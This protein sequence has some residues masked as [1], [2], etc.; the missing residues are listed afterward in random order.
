MAKTKLPANELIAEDYRKHHV[1]LLRFTASERKEVLAELK[2]MQRAALAKLTES[3]IT[4]FRRTKIEALL[5][6]IN[7]IIEDTYNAL[8]SRD[9]TELAE[10][11]EAFARKTVGP[12]LPEAVGKYNAL[13]KR[14]IQNIC[15]NALIEGAPSA[16]WWKRQSEQFKQFFSDTVRQGMMEGQGISEIAQKIARDNRAQQRAE[17][18]VRSSVMEVANKTREE[19]FRANADVVKGFQHVSTF[20]SRTTVICAARDGLTWDLDGNPIGHDKVFRRPPLHFGCLTG[21]SLVSP[22]GGV[23][24]CSKRWI[25][26]ELVFIKTSS[27]NEL[28]CTPNHPIL[29]PH[30]WV[31]AGELDK[32]GSVISYFGG[33]GE[34]FCGGNVKYVPSVLE[35]T[36]SSFLGS[37]SVCPVP[38]PVSP[39]DFHGDG[40]A[41]EIAIIGAYGILRDEINVSF[42]EISHEKSFKGGLLPGLVKET[43]YSHLAMLHSWA[44]CAF[45]SLICFFSKSLSLL[46]RA[47]VHSC[48][49][50]F[51]S[52]PNMDSVL[53]KDSDN[54]AGGASELFGDACGSDSFCVKGNDL[55]GGDVVSFQG[56]SHEN[57]ILCED[58]FNSIPGNAKPFGNLGHSDIPLCIGSND[59]G[60]VYLHPIADG[61]FPSL[62]QNVVN[63]SGA[64][65]VFLGDFSGGYSVPVHVDNVVSFE[66][67]KFSGHVYNLQ[68]ES[69][70]YIANGII[71][72]NCRS[73]LI[74]WLYSWKELGLP[75]DEIPESTRASMDGQVP[76]KM[77]MDDWLKTKDDSFG[78]ELLGKTRYHLWKDGKITLSQLTDQ[79]GRELT[80]EELREKYGVNVDPAKTFIAKIPSAQE[81]AW[82][83]EVFQ[84]APEEVRRAIGSLPVQPKYIETKGG[85]SAALD[86]SNMMITTGGDREHYRHALYHE[87]GHVVDSQYRVSGVSSPARASEAFLSCDSSTSLFRAI[88]K[89]R[90]L[91]ASS[92]GIGLLK[93]EARVL[94]HSGV[95][96]GSFSND[97]LCSLMEGKVSE[98]W[99]HS[100]DYYKKTG[101]A[102]TEI[103]AS[104]F[105]LKAIRADKAY[106]SIKSLL[107]STV[108]VFEEFL[109]GFLK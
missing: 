24:S 29:T 33:E 20:D 63:T 55:F 32:V 95:V 47:S 8:A 94:W 109:K 31:P 92:D 73:T 93:E 26:G 17:L 99:G 4:E 49:L 70:A 64:P 10:I 58:S 84:D 9:M 41:S 97:I 98:I 34:G 59:L 68:T 80:V 62:S 71:T 38:V 45:D 75:F 16:E 48:P 103:F 60:F 66:R 78:E 91:Y 14:Q 96:T 69:S 53:R 11:E 37:S 7:P 88:E 52:V 106:S 65:P 43:A 90:A 61:M 23:S 81:R 44:S 102:N 56:M 21:N 105:A 30:G 100:A 36:V 76:A 40:G 13:T 5:R 28:S 50:L 39:E 25:E 51:G 46:K 85:S 67:R 74:P 2:K 82:A 77:N 79:A 83:E 108:S 72:H 87:I 42:N 54:H 89:D 57:I 18:L 12:M 22:I 15:S 86:G 101:C 35:D 104:L 3:D 19:S 27:D 1:S 6:Q 107:P